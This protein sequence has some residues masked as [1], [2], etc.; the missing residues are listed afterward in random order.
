MK[1]ITSALRTDIVSAQSRYN[2]NRT[3]FLKEMKKER[4]VKSFFL[5]QPYRDF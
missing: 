1:E 3:S 4:N 5:K 2:N